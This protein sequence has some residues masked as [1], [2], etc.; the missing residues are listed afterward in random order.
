[1]FGIR[2]FIKIGGVWLWYHRDS[3]EGFTNFYHWY[4]HNPGGGA[5]YL[6]Q[7]MLLP[8]L[9]KFDSGLVQ[10]YLHI[11]TEGGGELGSDYVL[12]NMDGR[13]IPVPDRLSYQ[14]YKFICTPEW[15]EFLRQYTQST[16]TVVRRKSDPSDDYGTD[17][18]L[19]RWSKRFVASMLIAYD[20]LQKEAAAPKPPPPKLPPPAAAPE[21]ASLGTADTNPRSADGKR[22]VGPFIFREDSSVT[23]VDDAFVVRPPMEESREV[24]SNG[25]ALRWHPEGHFMLRAPDGTLTGL[26]FL[27]QRWMRRPEDPSV[28]W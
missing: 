4:D 15:I 19:S 23:D 12:F 2:K 17:F 20:A 3:I 16:L 25:W 26:K 24:H 9:R 28:W 8:S 27:N 18:A 10:M 22:R 13:V 21:P 7:R 14:H 6:Y 11:Y 5:G 1:M